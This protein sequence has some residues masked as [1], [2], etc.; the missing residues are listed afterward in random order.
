M[1]SKRAASVRWPGA[2][3]ACLSLL[4]TVACGASSNEVAQEPPEAVAPTAYPRPEYQWLSE[5]GLFDDPQDLSI[6]RLARGFQ[7]RFP[8][9]SDGAQKRRWLQLPRGASIDTTEIDHWVF[10]IGTRLWKEFSEDGVLLETRLI[11]RYGEGPEDY[12]MGAF[13]WETDEA[14][15]KLAAD[16]RADLRGTSHDAPSQKQCLACHNGETGRVLGFS[17]LQLSGARDGETGWTL[18]ELIRK[19]QLSSPPEIAALP[20]VEAEAVHLRALGYLHGNC[21]HCHNSR[22]TAWPDTQMVLRLDLAGLTLE[23][24]RIT[25]SVVRKKAQNFRALET[26]YLVLPG[27]PEASILIQ[28][29]RVRGPREQMPPLGTEQVDASGVAWVSDWI[30]SLSE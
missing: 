17:A 19:G 11:E 27:D 13:V 9:W 24:D 29:M 2:L 21:G 4:G 26:P 22:G 18:A 8:L 14:D 5:T 23:T 6:S 30:E 12:W 15:A 20:E 7:P 1:R 28:R 3:A 25:Q 10:P 16:G